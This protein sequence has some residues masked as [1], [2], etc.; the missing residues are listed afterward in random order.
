MAVGSFINAFEYRLKHHL[1]FITSHSIC[2]QCKHKL[3]FFD[4]V[5]IFS[6]LLLRRRCRYCQGKISFQYPLVELITGILFLLSYLRYYSLLSP[7]GLVFIWSALSLLEV[8]FLYDFKYLIIPDEALLFGIILILFSALFAK[9]LNFSPLLFPVSKSTLNAFSSALGV[10][11]F[12]LF[13]VFATNG[14]GMGGGDVKLVAFLGLILGWPLIL[15][16]LYLAFL[17]GSFVGLFL[18]AIKKRHFGETIPFGPFLCA[19][20]VFSLLYPQIMLDFYQKV[21]GL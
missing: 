21:L 4:L 11:A 5:P 15:L 9:L 7:Y 16:S 14:R 3:G 10:G 8:I 6:W 19:A 2:P 17:L 13:L 20:A 1:P 12:F 18:I